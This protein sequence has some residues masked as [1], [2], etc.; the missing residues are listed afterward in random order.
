MSEH[1]V[2]APPLRG[3]ELAQ[4]LEAQDAQTRSVLVELGLAK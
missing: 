1:N 3:R 4:Y 2:A